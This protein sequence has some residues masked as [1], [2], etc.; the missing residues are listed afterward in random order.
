[1]ISEK[2][3]NVKL[4]DNLEDFLE[5]LL[6]E[7][8][9]DSKIVSIGNSLRM[10][11]CSFCGHKDCLTFNKNIPCYNC[12]SCSEHGNL[13]AYASLVLG[14]RKKALIF[15]GEYLN[16]QIARMSPE[17]IKLAKERG[18]IF[19][20][21]LHY[22]N[23]CH[24]ELMNDK[25]YLEYQS[26]ERRHNKDT[27]D[28]Y[29]VG[30]TIDNKE[31]REFLMDR[32]FSNKEMDEAKIFIPKGLFVYPYF[33][34]NKNIVRFNTK[35]PFETKNGTGGIIKGYSKGKKTLYRS[36][37]V[38]EDEAI[39]VEGENDL[40]SV[41][42]SGYDSVIAIGGQPS[43]EQIRE[44]KN[45]KVL[46]LC[47]D[48]DAA[49]E[50]YTEKINE[51]L[52]HVRIKR[53]AFNENYKDID[54]YLK[55]GGKE[56]IIDELL[57]A[58]IDMEN[59]QYQIKTNGNKFEFNNRKRNINLKVKQC[60]N[61]KFYVDFEYID[62]EGNKD[63]K[64]N[65]NIEKIGAKYK[66]IIGYMSN[67]LHDYYFDLKGKSLD[68]VC[69]LL[70]Q[71]IGN[72]DLYCSWIAKFLVRKEQDSEDGRVIKLEELHLKYVFKKI[73]GQKINQNKQK[74]FKN[75]VQ[76][77]KICLSQ[78]FD[79]D[80]R[81]GYMYY[82]RIINDSDDC[83]KIL[84]TWLSSEKSIIEL[85]W[86]KRKVPQQLLLVENAFILPTE[87]ETSIIDEE[88]S[89]L[90]EKYVNM[91]LGN[92]HEKIKEDDLS[93][94][95][96][97]RKLEANFCNVY[98]SGNN[99][100]YKV[101][102]AYTLSTYFYQV[103]RETGYLYLKGEKGS[104]KSLLC[105]LLETY[106][107]CPK[108]VVSTTEA[109]LFRSIDL[110]GGTFIL[111][112]LENLGSR[113][114]ANDSPMGVVLKAGYN[115][116]GG[117]TIRTNKD[118][119]LI[120]D[121][122]SLY[123]PKIIS[124]IV[125][126]EDVIGDRCIPINIRKYPVSLVQGKENIKIYMD[127][128]KEE[129]KKLTSLCC[130]GVLEHFSEVYEAYANYRMDG[131]S[132]RNVQIMR[133]LM[134]LAHFIGRDY[135]EAI[136]RYYE[137]EMKGN[138]KWVE[139]NTPEG[140]VREILRSIARELYGIDEKTLTKVDEKNSNYM[141]EHYF[142]KISE[143]HFKIN[144]FA[145]KLLLDQFDGSKTYNMRSTHKTLKTVTKSVGDWQRTSVSFKLDDELVKRNRNN[146]TLQCYWIVLK[147][148]DYISDEDIE[149]ERRLKEQ[150][151]SGD[152]FDIDDSIDTE[153]GGMV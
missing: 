30:K 127:K 18:K 24:K 102:A 42:E 118:K 29:L 135:E 58:A 2:E 6:I 72:D 116:D 97:V 64:R 122:F 153:D 80:K 82:N 114:R 41:V 15:I 46:A 117:K 81:I 37:K 71:E 93:L 47:F 139:I 129:N 67:Y 104:G 79:L 32:G 125:G 99:D 13:I 120:V 151:V 61:E 126:I 137:E 110:G 141:K 55:K 75:D 147:R 62:S 83:T 34:E 63:Q 150:S 44:M 95:S 106:C 16:I 123:G 23:L 89:S 17:E 33:D 108:Y 31:A 140:M 52:P 76:Y 115:K 145:I 86:Y 9:V 88:T 130:L 78:S 73:I 65:V 98:Y 68:Y 43:D 11:P 54:E 77:Q 51:E 142:K 66:H 28:E 132:A 146:S 124:C 134:V 92:A 26:L 50:K 69:D 21:R 7:G 22:A 10:Q 136:Q 133:P 113:E 138:K 101:L 59:D 53:I 57:E 49:G 90:S 112:E 35:N 152:L 144:S 40:L 25:E 96:L 87:I 103:F 14:N 105:K 12:F 143:K 131:I 19:D 38:N 60:K 4:L 94:S 109:A 48:N 39:V 149:N 119:G 20:I 8:E 3:A 111:D 5:K 74:Y 91:Y 36:T 27:L 1:M 45:F 100:V 107:F 128:N 56:A 148:S 70:E 121:N 85:D 84:P